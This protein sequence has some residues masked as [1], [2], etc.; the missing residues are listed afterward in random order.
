MNLP[1]KSYYYENQEPPSEDALI[2]RI[3]DVCLEFPGYG[4]RRVTRQLHREGWRINH[5]KVCRILREKGWLCRPRKKKWVTTTDSHHGFQIYPNLVKNIRIN[6]INQVWV[7]DITYIHILVCFV[8]LAVILD[9]YSRKAVGYALSRKIDTNLTMN[10][11]RMATNDRQPAPGCIHHSDRG[12]QYASADYV[13][14]LGYYGFQ[15]SMSR[16]GNPY[17]NAYA[18]SFIKTLKS[19]EVQLWEYRTLSDVQ[20]R[21]PYFI[22]DVYNQKRLHS[23]L[24]YRPPCEFEKMLT[25]TQNPCQGTL[26]TAS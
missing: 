18:E 10:A 20:K 2:T 16:K 21:I 11:L 23:S 12:I 15:I 3:G 17:D 5:K 4:Y 22:E 26:I 24:G 19:E 1:R 9:V 6:A 25:L 8:Y 13:K 7:A 14:E